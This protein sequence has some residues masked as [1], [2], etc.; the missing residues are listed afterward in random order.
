MHPISKIIQSAEKLAGNLDFMRVDF[1]LTNRESVFIEC[2]PY[3]GAGFEKMSYWAS[4]Y[5]GWRWDCL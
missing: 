4:K 1:L 5:F 3:P 2:A